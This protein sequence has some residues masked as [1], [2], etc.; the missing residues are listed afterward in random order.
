MMLSAPVLSSNLSLGPQP[1][2]CL[3]RAITLC[4]MYAALTLT[5][6]IHRSRCT[7]VYFA[8]A[9]LFVARRS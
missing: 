3:C 1:G 2:S 4:F 5:F 6:N 7:V 8:F 9:D